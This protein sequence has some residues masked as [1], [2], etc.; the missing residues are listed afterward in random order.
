MPAPTTSDAFL[1]LIRKS[2]IVDEAQLDA[3]IESDG[4]RL[5]DQ[6]RQLADFLIRRGLIT[7]FQASQV[8]SGK[9]RG[10]LLAGGKYKLLELL[11]IGG[12]GKVYLCEHRRMKR[13]V[14]IKVLPFDRLSEPT[15]LERF[16]REARAAGV[17]DH[18]NIVRAHDLDQD[19]DLHFLVMEYVDGA[20]LF[21]IVKKSGPMEI[22]RA[23]HYISQAAEGLQYAHEAAGLVHRDIKPGN[24]LVDR[25]GTV[26]ILDMGLARFFH[27]DAHPLTQ[28]YEQNAVLG[29][30]EYLP[31]EQAVNSSDVDIRADIY[32]LGA[33]L[34]FLLAGRGPFDNGSVADKLAWH[35]NRE[36]Q[37]VREIRS[38]VPRALEQVLAKMMA[39]NRAERYAEPAAVI[40][41]L[42]AWTQQPIAPPSDEEMPKRCPALASPVYTAVGGPLTGG[43]ATG[44]LARA[45]SRSQP[46]P[47]HSRAKRSPAT[48]EVTVWIAAVAV[49]LAAVGAYWWTNRPTDAKA[50]PR[51]SIASINANPGSAGPIAVS[52]EAAPLVPPPADRT[53]FVSV[54]PRRQAGAL[55]RQDVADSL[56]VALAKAGPNSRVVVLDGPVEG[57]LI[58]DGARVPGL[59]IEGRGENG[60]LIDWLVPDGGP[61]EQPLLTLTNSGSAR[62]SGFRF[63]GGRRLETVVRVQGDSGGLQLERLELTNGLRTPLALIAAVASSDSPV[64]IEHLRWTTAPDQPEGTIT[65]E[66][67]LVDRGSDNHGA[68]AIA[69]RHCRIE[70]A[71]EAGIR[72][73]GATE[74]EIR[75]N[76]F[77]AGRDRAGSAAI[78]ISAPGRGRMKLIVA[79]NTAARF[80]SLLRFDQLPDTANGSR[81][82]L[83][84]NLAIG[85]EAFISAPM[86]VELA[87]LAL[88]FSGSAGNVARPEDCNRGL[89]VIDKVTVEFDGIDFDP[90][91]DRFLRY[92]R[93]P[94]SAA[95]LK[96]GAGGEPAGVP[97]LD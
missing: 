83:R 19:G 89:T 21:D 61:T 88:L 59:V 93:S 52:P 32:S 87:G 60:Q 58:V 47:T 75:G 30:A 64:V 41:A 29:T 33:T 76:R 81:V 27:D 44:S 65:P 13:L 9:W 8:L 70:G 96:A 35:Q 66:A 85:A 53:M 48:G 80:A 79:S 56:S 49:L 25:A 63:D 20:T 24:L 90:K 2:S 82:I 68:L 94:K 95:L 11:G 86:S 46:R 97:P 71:F 73:V 72:M 17:L 91:T 69:V 15:C 7:V 34:Y 38:D 12:M 55:G 31:P 39:K 42:Q 18:P 16:E 10:F 4:A 3:L 22:E 92:C 5:P 67:M 6:P 57:Q 1:E 40:E 43:G 45:H 26:K 36:P 51:L 23:C 50:T 77:W 14:A 62:I 54:D 74:A 84:S 78:V 28:R 37:P